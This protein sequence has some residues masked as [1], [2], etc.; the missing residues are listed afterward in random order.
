MISRSSSPHF[1]VD[2]D[3]VI[4]VIL[5]CFIIIIIFWSWLLTKS[6][7]VLHPSMLIPKG[8]DSTTALPAVLLPRTPLALRAHH[9]RTFYGTVLTHPLVPLRSLL[10]HLSLALWYL[11]TLRYLSTP[12]IASGHRRQLFLHSARTMQPCTWRQQFTWVQPQSD[13]ARMTATQLFI[14]LVFFLFY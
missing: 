3:F 2:A 8:R 4:V 10:L 6:D 7:L 13:P 14:A 9:H 11:S 5:F 1:C 12:N